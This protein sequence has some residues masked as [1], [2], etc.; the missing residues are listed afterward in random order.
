MTPEY[1]IYFTAKDG[2]TAKITGD[3]RALEAIEAALEKAGIKFNEH[4]ETWDEGFY[5]E[6]VS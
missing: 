6:E 2:S 1:S 3:L 5:K 4:I